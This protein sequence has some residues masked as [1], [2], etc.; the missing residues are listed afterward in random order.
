[1]DSTTLESPLSRRTV[2]GTATAGGLLG[3]SG[4]MRGLRNLFRDDPADEFSLSVA[5]VSPADDRQ[6]AAVADRLESALETAGIDVERETLPQSRFLRRILIDHEFDLFVDRTPRLADPSAL[7][8]LLH[9]RFDAEWGWQNPYGFS[10][11]SFDTNLD[12]QRRRTGAA[13]ERAVEDTLESFAANQP[14]SPLCRP[15]SRH[16]WNGDR[17]VGF[18][19]HPLSERYAFVDIESTAA[20]GTLRAVVTDERVTRHFNPLGIGGRHSRSPIDDLLYDSLATTVDGDVRPWL[21]D[22]WTWN[23]GTA[24]LTLRETSWHDGEPVSAEDVAF[25]YD[26]LADTSMDSAEAPIPAPLYRGLATAIADVTR[27]DDHRVRITPEAGRAATEQAFTIPILPAHLW[28]DRTESAE[29]VDVE[30]PS[31]ATVAVVTD[32]VPPIGSGLF[33]FDDREEGERLTLSRNGDH[34]TTTAELPE[35]P[36]TTFEVTVTEDTEAAVAAIE[37]GEADLTLSAL[38][39]VMASSY[40]AA[41]PL[42]THE[43]PSQ[44]LYYIGYNTRNAPLLNPNFRRTIAGLLDKPSLVESVFAGAATPVASPLGEPWQPDSLAWDGVDP[45]TPFL[46]EDGELDV[47]AVRNEFRS[48][49]H[50]YD[51]DGNLLVRS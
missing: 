2:L 45:V 19:R 29:F 38:D 13:R 46:G 36:I 49:G 41:P 25:T 43:R 14:F 5:S 18:D 40:T 1:M 51:D 17:F 4:C 32:N 50:R 6:A 44:S 34:F 22:S 42:V 23:D 12:R 26:F 39:P 47:D 16:V 27:L 24:T 9:T 11:V 15:T 28:R 21:A 7:Y 48:I 33:S 3:L 20:D 37:D 35:T 10:N 8:G 30:T 31:G